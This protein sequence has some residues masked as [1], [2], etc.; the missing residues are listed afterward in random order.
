MP[1]IKA[2]LVAAAAMAMSMA[3]PVSPASADAGWPAGHAAAL[4]ARAVWPEAVG[5]TQDDVLA[6]CRQRRDRGS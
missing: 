5:L 2:P 6:R 1:L 3:V 4:L